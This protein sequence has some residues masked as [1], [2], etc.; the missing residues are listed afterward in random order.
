MAAVEGAVAAAGGGAKGLSSN[1]PDMFTL[2]EVNSLGQGVKHGER[3]HGRPELALVC[4][5]V[6]FFSSIFPLS[7]FSLLFQTSFDFFSLSFSSGTSLIDPGSRQRPIRRLRLKAGSSN[8][9]R[10]RWVIFVITLN[11]A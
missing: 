9:P 11:Y 4:Q 3:G 8:L 2:G 5:S 7:P 6:G 1:A 10:S